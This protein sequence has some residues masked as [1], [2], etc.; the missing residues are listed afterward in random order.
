MP[1]SASS[2]DAK[3]AAPRATASSGC[4]AS[5]AAIFERGRPVTR[6]SMRPMTGMRLEPP[7]SKM[8]A[9]VRRGAFLRAPAPASSGRSTPAVSQTLRVSLSNLFSSGR[10]SV[11]SAR[12]VSGS[13]RSTQAPVRDRAPEASVLAR[14]LHFAEISFCVESVFLHRSA[15]SKSRN[16][17]DCAC[18]ATPC[19]EKK[20]SPRCSAMAAS[21]S[22]PPSF[23]SPPSAIKFALRALRRTT[24]ASNVPPP[25]SKTKTQLSAPSSLARTAP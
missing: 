1:W 21:K 14:H 9:S 23:A 15:S 19:L 5:L 6:R 3:M 12:R 22:S 18:T 13:S 7:T 20:A 24:E 11:S 4:T 25:R 16:L 10:Q 17:A 2:I 8:R